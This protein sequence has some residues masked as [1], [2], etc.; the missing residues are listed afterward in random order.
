MSDTYREGFQ[1][2]QMRVQRVRECASAR[3]VRESG[4]EEKERLQVQEE[5]CLLYTATGSN[6]QATVLACFHCWD[7]CSRGNELQIIHRCRPFEKLL[8]LAVARHPEMAG[9]CGGML[10]RSRQEAFN[11]CPGE[12]A[13]EL[14][15]GGGIWFRVTSSC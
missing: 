2:E 9:K 10:A 11:A 12:E 14:G 7:I 8:C 3:V 13:I 4:E 6:G 1:S 15:K 5:G